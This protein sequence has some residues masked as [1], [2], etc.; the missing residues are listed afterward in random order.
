MYNI[1]YH[2]NNIYGTYDTYYL[3]NAYSYPYDLYNELKTK[4]NFSILNGNNIFKYQTTTKY[5]TPL[6]IQPSKYNS[7]YNYK[8]VTKTPSLSPIKKSLINDFN[9]VKLISKSPEPYIRLNSNNYNT[10]NYVNSSDYNNNYNNSLINLRINNIKQVSR[11]IVLP[12]IPY[13][14]PNEIKA[15]TPEPNL[16]GRKKLKKKA[17]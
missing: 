2:N 5:L 11:P 4:Q 10:G 3:N 9:N 16:R 15:K 7:D 17:F 12:Q 13:Y 14:N 6:I 1:N 8:Y